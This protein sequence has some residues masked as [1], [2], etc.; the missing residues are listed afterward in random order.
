MNRRLRKIERLLALQEQLH[1]LAEWK[2]AALDRKKAE[3]ASDQASLVGALNRDDPLHGVFI[4]A[5]ARR[6]NALAR[7]ADRVNR[8]RAAASRRLTEEGLTL[9]RAERMTVRAANTR[10]SSAS[11]ALP[12]SSTGSPNPTMQASRK[13]GQASSP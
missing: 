1:R 3:L 6:L 8:A 12:I 7:E 13:L 2:L 4:E 10:K 9:K 11:A 5:M